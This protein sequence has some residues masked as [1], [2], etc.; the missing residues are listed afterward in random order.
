MVHYESVTINIQ[1]V[2]FL[3]KLTIS[4]FLEEPELITQKWFNSKFVCV[5]LWWIAFH[6]CHNLVGG[7]I[8]CVTVWLF[9]PISTQTTCDCCFEGNTTGQC[10]LCYTCIHTDVTRMLCLFGEF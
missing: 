7:T 4:S 8:V 10:H 2:V 1:S 3:N 9:T 6:G 5:I